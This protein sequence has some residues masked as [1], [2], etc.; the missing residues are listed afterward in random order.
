MPDIYL[1]YSDI[2][3]IP[4]LKNRDFRDECIWRFQGNIRYEW[5]GTRV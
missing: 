3:C 4:W 1:I 5:W 2:Q